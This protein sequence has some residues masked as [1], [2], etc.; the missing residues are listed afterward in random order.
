MSVQCV[1]AH[2][3]LRE[4]QAVLRTGPIFGASGAMPGA[5]TAIKRVTPNSASA[6][7]TTTA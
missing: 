7:N 2:R 6:S 1:E 4:V 3:P 5:S